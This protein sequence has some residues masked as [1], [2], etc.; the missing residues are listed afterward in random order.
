MKENL[1]LRR[2][3]ALGLILGLV[4]LSLLWTSKA[5]ASNTVTGRNF[6]VDFDTGQGLAFQGDDT[7]LIEVTSGVLNAS[8]TYLW[9]SSRRGEFSFTA[10]NNTELE[11]SSPDAESGVDLSILG[12]NRTTRLLNFTWEAV[13]MAGDTVR[14]IWG[15]R[16]ES[17]IDKYTML[18]IG[19]SGL[20]MMVASPSWVAWQLKSGRIKP[21]SFEN[22]MYGLLIFCVGF[23]LLV[24]WLWAG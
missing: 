12:A 13:V 22:M 21:E 24:M 11:L 23:G 9:M 3:R 20:I 5:P 8:S 7:L 1:N 17:W 18:G 16:L 10:I 6:I 2:L 14:I 4:L 15:W 19:I